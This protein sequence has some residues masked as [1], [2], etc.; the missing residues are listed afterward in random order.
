VWKNVHGL[1]PDV[2]EQGSTDRHDEALGV[3]ISARKSALYE[4]GDYEPSRPLSIQLF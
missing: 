2:A 1:T 3:A 4:T